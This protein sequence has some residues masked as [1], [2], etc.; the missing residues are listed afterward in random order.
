M[1]SAVNF[2]ILFRSSYVGARTCIISKTRSDGD[3]TCGIFRISYWHV[4]C[5]EREQ[6]GEGAYLLG[7]TLMYNRHQ[8]CTGERNDSVVM[9][10]AEKAQQ[11]F[12]SPDP[13]GPRK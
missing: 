13:T 1:A 3:V 11:R 2:D 12:G 7:L 5:D 8:M 10:R 6:E 9:R 4:A